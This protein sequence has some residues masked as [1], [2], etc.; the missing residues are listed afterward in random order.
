MSRFSGP[1]SVVFVAVQD[2]CIISPYLGI[3]NEEYYYTVI[4]GSESDSRQFWP[5]PFP[6][7]C[8]TSKDNFTILCKCL[9]LRWLG[10]QQGSISLHKLFLFWQRKKQE[11]K[12]NEPKHPH[13]YCLLI[14]V[15]ILIFPALDCHKENVESELGIMGIALR[16][17]VPNITIS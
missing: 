17:T 6:F 8:V 13:A 9:E 16:T 4:Y 10:S 1:R 11:N 5:F 15:L 12:Q 2:C 14:F 3:I 7:F